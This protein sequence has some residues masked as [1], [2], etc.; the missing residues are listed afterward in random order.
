MFILIAP[1]IIVATASAYLLYVRIV[2]PSPIALGSQIPRFC[3]VSADEIQDY[4][5]STKNN[6]NRRL[7]GCQTRWGRFRVARSYVA[8][9]TWNAKLFLQVARFESLKI[10]SGKLSLDYDPR[11]TLILRLAEDATAVRLL[12]MR[13]QIALT[14]HAV[15]GKDIRDYAA[16]RLQKL[17]G[18]YKHL[19]FDAVALVGM[20]KD[21]CYY[22]MLRE[23]LGLGSWHIDGSD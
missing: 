3:V 9:M 7:E 1:F 21:E 18:E 22:V 15:S 4:C 23:R 2:K 10:D 13:A 11:E 16:H 8:Q 14:I 17:V 20:S 19:E 6:S 5:E 12:L